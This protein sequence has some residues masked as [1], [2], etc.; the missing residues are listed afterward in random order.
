MSVIRI[1]ME[2]I[3]QEYIQGLTNV[4]ES[5]RTLLSNPRLEGFAYTR[6]EENQK[7]YKRLTGKYY[8]VKK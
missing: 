8:E 5:Y 4:I 1:K 6:I 2:K 7:E 3:Q